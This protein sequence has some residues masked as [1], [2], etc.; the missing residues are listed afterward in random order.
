[1][2]DPEVLKWKNGG[3][4]FLDLLEKCFKGTIATGLSVL[5]PYQDPPLFEEEANNG[6]DLEDAA[7][8]PVNEGEGDSCEVRQ[9]EV[10]PN[11]EP[12]SSNINLKTKRAT[13]GQKKFGTAEKLQKS[14]DRILDGMDQDSSTTT[15]TRSKID[16]PYINDKCLLMLNE[17][18]N[19]VKGSH[20]YFLAVRILTN[21]ENRIA[22]VHFMNNDREM[23][24][25][26]LSTLTEEDIPHPCRWDVYLPD[27]VFAILICFD[28]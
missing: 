24:M 17:V 20:L 16:D 10:Q 14:L 13:N 7:D 11:T 9:D 28:R 12:S 19:L 23:T 25:D 18:P 26:W 4:K 21:K 3:P 6:E 5:L 27:L 2:E 22:F 8:N 1:M 15:T